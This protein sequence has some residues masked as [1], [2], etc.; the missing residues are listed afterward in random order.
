[1]SYEERLKELVLFSLGKRRLRGS[2]IGYQ[3]TLL[4]R[5]GG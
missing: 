5:K 3:E 4:Y 1:M 2:G